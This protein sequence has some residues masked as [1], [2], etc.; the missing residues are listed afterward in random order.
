[1][2]F[3]LAITLNSKSDVRLLAQTARRL[4]GEVK[5]TK[6]N[7]DVATKALPKRRLPPFR[8]SEIGLPIGTKLDSTLKP[9]EKAIVSGEKRV[10]FRGE[11]MTLSKAAMILAEETGRKWP[12]I[13]GPMYWMHR[14]KIL[15]HL[16]IRDAA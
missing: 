15:H 9:G 2:T 4:G 12:R 8:F 13:Q 14:G 7:G 16:R 6:A 1:M 11:K 5:V 10:R 3:K